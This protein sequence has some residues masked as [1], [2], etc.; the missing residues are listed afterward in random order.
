[1]RDLADFIGFVD[2]VHFSFTFTVFDGLAFIERFFAAGQA[3]GYFDKSAF[4]E[5]NLIGHDGGAFFF[6]AAL[7]FAQFG[8]S[9]QEF[10][11]A[12]RHM[13]GIGTEF[14]FSDVK[15]ANPEFSFFEH[16]IGVRQIGIAIADTFH[17]GT[18]KHNTGIKFVDEI[19]FVRRF[20]IGNLYLRS[21]L[22]F[23][24]DLPLQKGCKCNGFRVQTIVSPLCGYFYVS[25]G[26]V[27]PKLF[28]IC[29]MYE[30][31]QTPFGS[32][33]RFDIFHKKSGNGFSIVPGQGANV[34]DIRFGDAPILDGYDS[35]EALE[36]GKWGKSSVLFPFPNRLAKG[37][38]QW[39]GKTYQFPINNVATGNAIHGFVREM[40]FEV[41]YCFL[42]KDGASIRCFYDYDGRRDYYPFPFSLELA[43]TI[44]NDGKFKVEIEVTNQGDTAMPFGFGWHPYFRLANAADAHSL[45]LPA[46]EKVA[47]DEHMIPTGGRSVYSDFASNHV[48]GETVLDTCFQHLQATGTPKLTLSAAGRRL[49]VKASAKEFPFFQVFTPPHRESIALEPMTCNVDAF[50]NKQG[51]LTLQPDKQWKGKMEISL[52][53]G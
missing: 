40:P 2:A 36:A 8:F 4:A 15:V 34:L 20:A 7:Q 29:A 31:R 16:T 42:A 53:D 43:F 12:P 25:G 49:N 51:L 24:H 38:Y 3:D 9:E 50:N 22:L 10:A 23:S 17:F 28:Y 37:S 19:I 13:V 11:L 35:P 21:F 41:E 27:T 39:L 6:D 18:G 48:V 14:V 33:T 46:C 1:M 47:I 26:V 30:L 52:T 44:S 5:E 45:K 32:H